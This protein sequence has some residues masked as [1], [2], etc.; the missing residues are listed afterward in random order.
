MLA[1]LCSYELHGPFGIMVSVYVGF[2]YIPN[3]SFV[4]FGHVLLDPKKFMNLY[5]FSIVNFILAVCLLNSV[6]VSSMFVLFCLYIMSMSSTDLKYP[7]IQCFFK[8]GHS[9]LRSI[10][11]TYTWA[12][13]A[14]VG[15]SIAN[16]SVCL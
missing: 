12:N 8:T 3:S 7:I 9:C 16:R 2:L 11:W 13:I 15:I 4:F 14:E 1:T 6:S 5:F 10:Y